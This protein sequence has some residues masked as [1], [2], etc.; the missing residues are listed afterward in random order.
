MKNFIL[1]LLFVTA[2]IFSGCSHMSELNVD[3]PAGNGD[4]V[5]YSV[6]YYIHADS[7]YLYHTPDGDPIRGNSKVLTTALE[8]GKSALSGEVFIF[9]QQP[10]RKLL[11]LFPRRSS[12]FYHYKNGQLVN[13]V[14]YL[15]RNKR[16]VFLTTEAELMTLFRTDDRTASHQNYFFYFGHEIPSENGKGYH[17]SLPDIDVN[18]ASL[19]GGIQ[20]FLQ[21]DQDRFSLVVL[22]TCN[23][24][25]PDM[26]KQL[27]PFTDLLLAS[28]Q[29]L[30]LSHINSDI[31]TLLDDKPAASP[32]QIA[33]LMAEQTYER[34][35]DEILTTITLT[36]YQLDDVEAY[37]GSLASFTE[38]HQISDPHLQFQDNVDCAELSFPDT[39]HYSDGIETWYKPARFGRKSGHPSHSGWGCKPG[40]K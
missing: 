33:R 22:S 38:S 5:D 19:A 3:T 11:G 30:H 17:Q 35:S 23:N 21:S 16:E 20:H 13:K 12:R 2:L 6:T 39:A 37:I 4:A 18:T 9:H 28:P 26:A 14:K 10:E 31:I 32:I 24:G 25:T 40:V 29:N 8:V 34:L 1:Y 15:H 27:I 36:L 7:D